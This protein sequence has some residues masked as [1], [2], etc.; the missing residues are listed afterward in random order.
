MKLLY[1]AAT[2]IAL[3]YTTNADSID[4]QQGLLR[5]S[6]TSKVGFKSCAVAEKLLNIETH[7]KPCHKAYL[8]RI[9]DEIIVSCVLEI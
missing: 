6:V 1:R 5:A 8:E 2:L 3:V 7:W 9:G 4:T